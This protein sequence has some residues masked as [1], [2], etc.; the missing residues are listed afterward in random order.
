MHPI[1]DY[2]H[3][4]DKKINVGLIGYGI[5]GQVFH[6]PILSSVK[7]LFLK[8]IRASK[9][10]QLALARQ[11][12]P[13]AELVPDADNI[14]L[15]PSIDLVVITTPNALHFPLAAQALEAGKAVVVD[16]P[17]TLT[18]VEADALIALAGKKNGIL[19]VF[20]NRRFDSEFRTLQK[21]IAS[22]ILGSIVELESRYDRFRN[23]LKPNAWREED[24]PG[25][26]IL[27]DLGAHLIDQSLVLFGL[28]QAI[29]ADIRMQRNGARADDY[30]ELALY[31]P[32]VKVTLRSGML[33]RQPLQRF[34][35][36]GT[37]GIYIKYGMDV[38]EEALKA[39][40]TPLNRPDWGVEPVEN[41][42]TINTS[43]KGLHLVGRIE[44]E[45][46]DY[47]DFYRNIYETLTGQSSLL[48]TAP[49]ARQVIRVIEIARQS[50]K[51]RRTI[52]F[53]EQ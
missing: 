10:E 34:A 17:F 51:E 25:A 6:A 36:M 28:P 18:S 24:I 26:G 41:W 42:G 48:V 30:F 4:M 43:C 1:I 35:L 7:G 52:D 44:S 47:S 32:R 50:S 14:I 15:D 9:P 31:Y 29:G 5:G 37:E 53:T 38:Q 40:F 2:F 12:Y 22:G 39:G 27:Y 13:E 19:S 23:Y 33:V 45:R 46:G 11:R 21:V 20:Q 8:K 49:E 16:K 3:G